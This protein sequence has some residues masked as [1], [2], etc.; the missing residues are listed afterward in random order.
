MTHPSPY[1]EKTIIEKDTY[2]SVFTAALFTVEDVETTQMSI[3]RR[4]DKEAVVVHTMTYIHT[5]EYYSAIGRNTFE[6]VLMRWMVLERII[7]SE[8]SQKEKNKC[9]VLMYIYGIQ[10]NGS[11]E[12]IYRAAMEIEGGG[13]GGMNGKL[14][15]KHIRYHM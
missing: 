4:M 2:T 3:N 15:W 12:P 11:V 13:E 9:C 1:P 5:M 14:A 8:A 7:R 10:K 6:S